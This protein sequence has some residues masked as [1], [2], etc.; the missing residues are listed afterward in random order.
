VTVSWNFITGFVANVLH[1]I[2]LLC[3]LMYG[4]L[5]VEDLMLLIVA[6]RNVCL[7]LICKYYCVMHLILNNLLTWDD[8]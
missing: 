3:D 5:T 4:V 7:T 2:L 8:L 6:L 1:R